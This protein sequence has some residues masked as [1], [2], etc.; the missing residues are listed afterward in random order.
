MQQRFYLHMG[1]FHAL[2][3][4]EALP[5]DA[6]EVP[7]LPLA[8]EVW[9]G[10]EFVIDEEFLADASL[11]VGHIHA[12]HMIKMIEAAVI[13]SGVT[14]D[15]GLIADEAEASGVSLIDL[16]LSVHSH[17]APFRHAETARRVAK[18]NARKSK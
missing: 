18:T 10:C 9:N 11:P 16:A 13:L 4:R 14:L 2:P 15:H 1:A 7:R 12:A 17:A 8:G 3:D 6:V 5:A